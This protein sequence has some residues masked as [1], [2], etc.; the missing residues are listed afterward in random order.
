[1]NLKWFAIP[2]ATGAGSGLFLSPRN[3]STSRSALVIM[4][5]GLGE[6]SIFP[7]W[8]WATSLVARG[9]PVLSV[10]WD[11]HGEF[12]HSVLDISSATR[13]I[14]LVLQKIYGD[15][16]G[17]TSDSVADAP[18]CFLMGNSFG[19]VLSLVAATRPEIPALVSGVIAVSP[20]VCIDVSRHQPREFLSKLSPRSF[21]RDVFPR[22][23]LYGWDAM[24]SKSGLFKGERARV[25]MRVGIDPLDQV[26]AFL[27]ETVSRRQLLRNVRVPVLWLHGVK[28][29]I[30]PLEKAVPI[31]SEIPSALFS[32][33]DEKR[34]HRLMAMS[35]EI[36]EYAARFV[37]KCIDLHRC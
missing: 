3:V 24:E 9:I 12:G 20:M 2:L 31:M 27:A 30:V 36:P 8:H 7:Q 14:P 16:A 32:H 34:G 1:V 18:R 33:F 23:S 25:R 10:T 19:A 13:T 5:H 35:S 15:S 29:H 6:D 37:E 4:L 11:G 22:M 28:D 26:R 21:V 17:S